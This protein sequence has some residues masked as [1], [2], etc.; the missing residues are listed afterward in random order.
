[1]IP[2]GLHAFSKVL[3]AFSNVSFKKVPS[4][5]SLEIAS[6]KESFETFAALNG[7]R[8]HCREVPNV[9]FQGNKCRFLVKFNDSRKINCCFHVSRQTYH[10]QFTDN[11]FFI[12]TDDGE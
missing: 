9:Q 11:I 12:I 3:I 6:S 10:S 2:E 1:M 5:S 4:V 7:W 8:T